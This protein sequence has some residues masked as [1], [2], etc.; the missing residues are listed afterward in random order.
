MK[1]DSIWVGE[2]YAAVRRGVPDMSTYLQKVKVIDRQH[3]SPGRQKGFTVET[4]AT[5]SREWE[6]K[7]FDGYGRMVL[8]SGNFYMPWYKL[9]GKLKFHQDLAKKQ[10][11]EQ[12]EIDRGDRSRVVERLDILEKINGIVGEDVIDLCLF[13]NRD[14]LL[15]GSSLSLNW[16]VL[17]ALLEKVQEVNEVNETARQDAMDLLGDV[18]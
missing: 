15:Q 18:F 13:A 14:Y 7:D 2:Y 1:A 4:V 8:K 9:A 16:D 6:V 5:L 17:K 3:T 11:A 12:E 10:A